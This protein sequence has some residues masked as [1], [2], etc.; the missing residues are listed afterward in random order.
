MQS[1][2]QPWE[3]GLRTGGY[4]RSELAAVRHANDG[5]RGSRRCTAR[6]QLSISTSGRGPGRCAGSRGAWT[7]GPA[8]GGL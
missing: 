1:N 4:P 3:Q 7:V 8:L 6:E 5:D 2:K